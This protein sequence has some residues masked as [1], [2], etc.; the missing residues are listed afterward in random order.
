MSLKPVYLRWEHPV[1]ADVV[2]RS[3]CA[4]MVQHSVSQ[5]SHIGFVHSDVHKSYSSSPSSYLKIKELNFAAVD[6]VVIALSLKC[7]PWLE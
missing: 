1:N 2:P 5:G 6:P 4:D 7:E 3:I